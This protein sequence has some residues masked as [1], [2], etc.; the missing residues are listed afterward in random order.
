MLMRIWRRKMFHE[1]PGGC[2]DPNLSPVW[3]ALEGDQAGFWTKG[4]GKHVHG[5]E[6]SR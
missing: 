3:Q 1:V 2:I 4:I 5:H 6:I